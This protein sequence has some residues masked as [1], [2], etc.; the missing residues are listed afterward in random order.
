MKTTW[1]FAILALAVAAALTALSPWASKSPD[2][3]EKV[4]AE[5]AKAAPVGGSSAAAPLADY[6]TPGVRH[7]RWST[8]LA[9]LAGVAAVFIAGVSLGRLLR[10]RARHQRARG[11]CSGTPTSR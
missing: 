10:A 3:L 4:A 7:D 9:G 1:T 8:I 11:H 5:H 2:G 6:K